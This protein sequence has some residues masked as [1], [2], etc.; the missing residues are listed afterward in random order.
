MTGEAATIYALSSGPPPAGIAVIRVSGPRAGGALGALAGGLP[1]PRRA[2]LRRLRD[3]EGAVIDEALVLWLPGPGSATGEDMGEIHCHGGRAVIGAV[4]AAVASAGPARLAEPGEFTERAFLNGRLDLSDVEALGDLIA[5]ET[6]AQ[7]RQAAGLMAGALKHR[8]EAWRTALLRA[9]ALVEVTIDWADEEVPE[10]VSPEVRGLIAGVA[11][12]IRHAL[13]VSAGAAR[14]REGFEVAILGAPNAG[15]SSLLNA[16]AGREAAITSPH[17]GTTR[18]VIELRYDLGGIP[19]VFLDTAGLRETADAVEAE[20]VARARARAEAAD[21]RLLLEAPDAPAEALGEAL[22]RPGDLRRAT[23]GDLTGAAGAISAA[24]GDGL[25]A[26]LA[27]I[28]ARLAD[29]IPKEGLVAHA[30]QARALETGL[31]ALDAAVEGLD[32]RGAEEV[33]EDLRRG[34]STLERLIGRVGVEEMLGEVF[35]RFCLGK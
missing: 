18:D 30:R 17:P 11:G 33:S 3:A 22:L 4:M 35:A 24:T 28:E 25:P 10:D 34:L 5:A 27:E 14:L 8:A 7:R 16:L 21:L 15:K 31:A 6:E 9:L 29:R 12:E 13:A 20:G 1:A 19:V 32:R 2:A 23:K 26:L